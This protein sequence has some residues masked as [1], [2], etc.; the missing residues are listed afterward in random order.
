MVVSQCDKLSRNRL[1]RQGK[2][3]RS[4]AKC[5]HGPPKYAAG[6]PTYWTTTFGIYT[7]IGCKWKSMDYYNW[8]E[9]PISALYIPVYTRTCTQNFCASL[10]IYDT[11]AR[12]RTH[13]ESVSSKE[14]APLIMRIMLLATNCMHQ[15]PW[16]KLPEQTRKCWWHTAFLCAVSV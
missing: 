6:V 3:V 11:H 5:E 12:A 13:A 1:D 4:Q 9:G 8:L 15:K 2:P 16:S 10:L 14:V 7:A